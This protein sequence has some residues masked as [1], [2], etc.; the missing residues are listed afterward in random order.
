MRGFEAVH[1]LAFSSGG[2]LSFLQQ[3]K[4]EILRVF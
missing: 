3:L 1:A 4:Q 2:P